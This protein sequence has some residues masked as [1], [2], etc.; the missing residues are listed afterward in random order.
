[1]NAENT[2]TQLTAYEVTYKKHAT[3]RKVR[4]WTRFATD[5]ESARESA[6]RAI[7]YEFYGNGVLVAVVETVDPREVA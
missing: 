3:A 1:M 7:D 5:I 6:L 4:T 2:S